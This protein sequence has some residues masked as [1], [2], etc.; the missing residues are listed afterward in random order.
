MIRFFCVNFNNTV[1]SRKLVRS[2][3]IQ[4]GRMVD[5]SVDC[6][7]EDNTTNEQEAEGC[8]SISTGHSWVTYIR[9]P[10]NL[11]YF[12]GLNYGLSMTEASD[13]AYVVV[14]N[15]D[16]EFEE[17]FCERLI[18]ATYAPNVFSVCPDVT[19][20]DGLHQ[21]PHIL[22]RISTLRRLQFDFYFAHYYV[23]RLLFL[24]LRLVRPVKVSPTQ[25]REG[26]ELHM[27]VGACYVLTRAF[28]IRFKNL[29]YPFFLYGEEAYISNQIHTAGGILWFDPHLHVRHA[30]SAALS[31]VPNRTAFEYARKGYR[32]YK[33]LL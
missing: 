31:R 8:Q 4:N 1:F 7:N 24:I 20:P 2:L 19:T 32:D 27:G 12:G 22:K 10:K 18:R 29:T 30:E 9:A 14:C 16:V 15:N 17:D 5:F 26:C 21:N 25:P 3:E 23:S 6:I 33:R 13:A 28:L 11:G